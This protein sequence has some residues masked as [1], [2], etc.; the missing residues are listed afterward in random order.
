MSLDLT[1]EE[2]AAELG[3][4]RESVYRLLRAGV[5]P[6][7]KVGLRQWRIPRAELQAYKEAGRVR[8]AGRPQL[9]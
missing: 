7:Y 3:L 4:H 6:G 2:V 5:L 1:P 8:G 9:E